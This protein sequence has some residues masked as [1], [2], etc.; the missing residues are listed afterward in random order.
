MNA[1]S[2]STI[3]SP[4][5]VMSLMIAFGVAFWCFREES[6]WWRP[7]LNAILACVGISIADMLTIFRPL[8]DTLLLAAI[9]M[10]VCYY[11]LKGQ[12]LYRHLKQ[13]RETLMALL[14]EVRCLQPGFKSPVGPLSLIHE[15]SYYD[16][17]AKLKKAC[18]IAEEAESEYLQDKSRELFMALVEKHRDTLIRK[19]AQSS[20]TDEY[21]RIQDSGWTQH[22]EYFISN[23]ALPTIQEKGL[24]IRFSKGECLDLL[25]DE[26]TADIAA[27][28]KIPLAL[29]EVVTGVDYEIF[30]AEILRSAGWSVHMTPASGD[31]G[32]DIIATRDLVRIAIQCKLYSSPVGNGSV[33]EVYSAKDFY[34]CD[35][36]IVVSNA[37][38]TKAARKAATNLNVDLVHHDTLIAAMEKRAAQRA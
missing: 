12:E 29:A 1:L 25:N 11:I 35:A 37:D 14:G 2:L 7:L 3:V 38:Y 13:R 17:Y 34:G 6:E 21:G 19:R 26:I 31:H 22:A 28:Q 9:L 33:Q 36:G 4:S 32:A 5:T 24:P 30:V 23:V 18:T 8:T 15:Q 20:F 10:P 27:D 16:A